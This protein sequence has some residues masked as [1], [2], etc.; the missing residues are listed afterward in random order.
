MQDKVKMLLILA[1][2]FSIWGSC[3]IGKATYIAIAWEKTEGT[4]VDIPR[5][6]WRCG[7]NQSECYTINVGYYAN[8]EFLTVDSDKIY[9]E[10]PNH[11]LDE[12][13]TVYYSSAKPW[14]AALGGSYG[15]LDQGII[16]FLISGVMFIIWIF[17]KPKK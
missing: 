8:K 5:H 12:K 13:V 11:L 3:K 4:V 15:S 16:M 10:P 7:K 2:V 6:I 17:S 9:Q 1:L 14:K